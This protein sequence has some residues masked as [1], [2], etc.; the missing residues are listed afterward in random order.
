MFALN[1][2]RK[3]CIYIIFSANLKLYGNFNMSAVDV[4]NKKLRGEKYLKSNAQAPFLPLPLK[5]VGTTTD[6]EL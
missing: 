6:N 1:G 4:A 3:K 5:T 2:R